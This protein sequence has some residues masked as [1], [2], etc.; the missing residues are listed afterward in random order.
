MRLLLVADGRSPHTVGWLRG[1]QGLGVDVTLLSS[2]RHNSTE[3]AALAQVVGDNAVHEPHDVWNRARPTAVKVKP[4]VRSLIGSLKGRVLT[5]PPDHEKTEQGLEAQSASNVQTSGLLYRFEESADLFAA[6]RLASRIR[7]MAQSKKPDLIHALRIQF[8]G[9][10]A[11]AAHTNLPVAVSTWGSDL[12]TTANFSARLFAETHQVVQHADAI[13][14]DCRRDVRLAKDFG[15]RKSAPTYVVPGNFGLDLS[16]FPKGS[17]GFVRELGLRDGPLVVYPRG[18]RGCIDHAAVLEAFSSLAACGIEASFLAVGLSD[19]ARPGEQHDGVIKCTGPLSHSEMLK[20]AAISRVTVSPSRSD[21]MP[22]SILEG[23]AG[24]S[25]P[26]C[27]RLE[28]LEELEALG[29]VIV[30]VEAGDASSIA[31]GIQQALVLAEDPAVRHRN[32]AVIGENFTVSSTES[33]VL[34]AYQGIVSCRP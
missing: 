29:A 21:G 12:I 13:F 23:M 15:L 31:R 24:G 33:A 16:S 22:N 1:L 2:R 18:V 19:V 32:Q 9:I 11:V 3:K 14:S 26:V 34:D 25:V 27:S 10:A 4:Y 28:S 30:W 5:R 7:S 17:T 8:E 20:A 6:Y